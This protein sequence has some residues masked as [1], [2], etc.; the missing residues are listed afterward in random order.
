VSG[1]LGG[2]E[3]AGTAASNTKDVRSSWRGYVDIRHFAAMQHFGRVWSKADINRQAMPVDSVKNEP[4][5]K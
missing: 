2:F 4:S 5:R 3:S 1:E